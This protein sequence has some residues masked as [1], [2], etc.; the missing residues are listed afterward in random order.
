MHDARTFFTNNLEIYPGKQPKGEFDL[1]NDVVSVVKRMT[2]PIDKSGR[3]ITMDNYFMDIPLAN[4]L[5]ANHRLT[6]VGTVRKNKRQLPQERISIHER[7]V[8]SSLFAF[9]KNPQQLYGDLIHS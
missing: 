6:V 4:D 9:S 7:S 8:L 1:G 3:N 2:K 5:Y